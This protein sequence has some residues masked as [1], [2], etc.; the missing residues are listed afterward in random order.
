MGQIRP[1]PQHL[2][3]K[4]AAGEV[5][6]RPASVVKEL[7]E[8]AL[9]AG[10]RRIEVH[11]EDGGKKRIKVTDDGVGIA[12][13][14][15][16]LALAP[17]ATSKLQKEDD[18]YCIRTM[19][20]RGE[21][22][23]SIAA[24]AQV[25]LTS[26][27]ADA[28]AGGTITCEAGN[29]SEPAPCGC[30]AG[31]TVE[32]RNLFFNTPARRKFLRT[33]ATEMGHITEQLA[34]IAL[35]HPQ[36]AF[37]LIHN[38]KVTYDLPAAETLRQRI[39]DFY[40]PELAE[41]LIAVQRQAE[42]FTL[43]ALISPPAEAKASP[44]WQYTWLNGRYIRDRFVQHAVREAYR[45][46]MDPNRQPVLFV[47]LR[48]DPA[49]FDVNVHPTKIEVR[50]TDSGLVHGLV[51]SALRESLLERD[52]TPA[53]QPG[54][55]PDQA[56]ADPR[57]E[58]LR[59]AIADFL[60]DPPP[61]QRRLDFGGKKY[62][63]TA[64]SGGPPK[65]RRDSVAEVLE[66]AFASLAEPQPPRTQGDETAQLR[67]PVESA[68]AAP[69][70]IQLHN[71][72]LLAETPDGMII[73]DQHALHERVLYEQF[74]SRLASGRIESQRLLLPETVSVRPDQVS[75]VLERAEVL[76]RLGI[77]ATPFGTDAIAV[78]AFPSLAIE[79][80]DVGEFMVELLERLASSP[81]ARDPE[82]FLDEA[83]QMMACKAAVKA[84]DALSQAE[85]EALLA[86]WQEVEASSA[87][88]H[89]RPTVLRLTVQ[90]L[91][92]QFK[93]A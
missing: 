87:C 20:F 82:K 2:Q 68:P 10:A 28:E 85:I 15:L 91:E 8:N 27:R 64:R 30:A 48:A 76:R 50:W 19:G 86:H 65:N 57:Q 9:D 69:K 80:V 3:N 47:H 21:A 13:E 12:L 75:L 84:G 33:A 41:C 54:R 73:V 46:L 59:R 49:C 31:T 67:E 23:A 6:E 78:Q 4:I 40:G 29:L 37:R 77:E 26:R 18:L 63:P 89:G 88:P 51:H 92:R 62:G 83:L 11:V 81:G 7:L 74:R 34:R 93:R 14:D 79:R 1:L 42:P 35:A 38:G 32:V 5:I 43:Y 70:A 58:R 45:G 22:L 53:L 66:D 16:P 61:A 25:S 55:E 39:A 44:R 52:L 56:D 17:H 90:D 71:T 36:V 60:R 24:I 72:Y